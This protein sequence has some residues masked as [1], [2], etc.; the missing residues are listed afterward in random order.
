[1]GYFVKGEKSVWDL[2]SIPSNQCGIFVHPGEVVWDHLSTLQ[3][4][5]WE[6]LSMESFVQLPIFSHNIRLYESSIHM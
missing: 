4:M 1:M 6:L 2:L 5:T 3:K